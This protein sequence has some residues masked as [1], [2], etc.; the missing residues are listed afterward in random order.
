MSRR[1]GVAV[2]I[3]FGGDEGTKRI[4]VFQPGFLNERRNFVGFEGLL[5]NLAAAGEVTAHDRMLGVCQ[6]ERAS[7]VLDRRA[8]KLCGVLVLH[9]FD[10]VSVGGAKEKTD[11]GIR[12]NSIDERIDDLTEFFLPAQLVV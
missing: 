9:L 11:H 1:D 5:E 2:R 12:E 4:G 3:G 7:L 8:E 10:P 6:V